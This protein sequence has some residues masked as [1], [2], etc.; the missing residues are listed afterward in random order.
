MDG[1]LPCLKDDGCIRSCPKA[2]FP[3]ALEVA[4]QAQKEKE[5]VARA[6]QMLHSGFCPH[7]GAKIE[8]E[9]QVGRCVYALPCWHRLYQGKAQS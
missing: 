2:I 6:L 3:T 1:K 5:A 9:R 8:Q 7:C 4:E